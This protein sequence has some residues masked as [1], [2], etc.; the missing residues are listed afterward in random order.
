MSGG[1]HM[2]LTIQGTHYITVTEESLV[3][4]IPTQKIHLIKIALKS[5]EPKAIEAI[6]QLFPNTNRYVVSSSANIRLYNEVFKTSAKKYYVEN[7]TNIRLVSFLR[8]NNKILLNINNLS[9]HNKQFINNEPVLED[10][11][12]NVEVVLCS[13]DFYELWKSLFTTWSGNL[14]IV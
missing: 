14:I 2:K 3:N 13:N 1:S 5:P 9:P 4:S 6:L 12:R 10:T 7:D 11:L 8:K